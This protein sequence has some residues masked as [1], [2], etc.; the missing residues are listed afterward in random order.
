MCSGGWRCWALPLLMDPSVYLDLISEGKALKNGI[1]ACSCVLTH[2]DRSCSTVWLP[3]GFPLGLQAQGR[4]R[5][6][7]IPPQSLL[8]LAPYQSLSLLEFKWIPE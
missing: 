4:M 6:V 1:P 8:R 2:W 3:W 7:P 5:A